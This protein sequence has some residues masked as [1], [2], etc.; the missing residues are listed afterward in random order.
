MVNEIT[1][2]EIIQQLRKYRFQAELN[3]SFEVAAL[4]EEEFLK[5][6]I[7]NLT[8]MIKAPS[9]K[10]T[11]SIFMKRYAFVAVMSLY[12]MTV[13]NK[14][15]NVSID[16]IFMQNPEHGQD[17]LPSFSIKNGA[18]S[19]EEWSGHNRKE[20]REKVLHELFAENISLLIDQ[21][22]KTFKISKLIL[23]ENIAVYLFWLYEAEL[24]DVVNPN[25]I[26]DFRFLIFEA[27]G[28]L[29]GHY[30]VNPLQK[31]YSKKKNI[32]ASDEEIRIRKTCC[33]NYTLQGASKNCKTCPCRK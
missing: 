27:E 7:E 31:Y 23:W 18:D 19:G 16:D 3:D 21:F 6:F 30:K 13:W 26:E 17:W 25:K 4:L 15:I 5:D 20:W 10:V 29:F 9:V 33:F 1:V 8:M 14:K 12:A 22:E 32:A 24:K 11:A 2:P 28:K